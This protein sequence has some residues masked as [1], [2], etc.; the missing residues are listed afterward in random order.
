M[1][2]SQNNYHNNMNMH[3]NS[4]INYPP[5]NLQHQPNHTNNSLFIGMPTALIIITTISR[6]F[7][8]INL[9]LF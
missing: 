9:K 6:L 3:N 4:M 8:D 7:S 5:N 1:M 2:H